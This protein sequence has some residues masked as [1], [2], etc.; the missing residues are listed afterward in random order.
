M[1]AFLPNTLRVLTCLLRSPGKT[2]GIAYTTASTLLATASASLGREPHLSRIAQAIRS[3]A[4]GTHRTARG[5]L[6]W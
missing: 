1:I 2:N 6:I 3:F 4:S 5:L